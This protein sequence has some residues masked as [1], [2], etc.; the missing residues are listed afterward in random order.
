[1]EQSKVEIIGR[2]ISNS[3]KSRFRVDS[4]MVDGEDKTTI[5]HPNSLDMT[6]TSFTKTMIQVFQR[7]EL[8]KRAKLTITIT[9]TE[10]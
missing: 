10:E 9:E 3:Q 7:L 2:Y 4:V 5:Q 8:Y 1:M 6:Q